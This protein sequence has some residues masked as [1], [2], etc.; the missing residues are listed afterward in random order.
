M[1]G[2][3]VLAAGGVILAG[4]AA[5]PALGQQS[6]IP[7]TETPGAETPGTETPGTEAPATEALILDPVV[8]T[9]RRTEELLED[10]PGSVV[11]LS[12]EQIDRS[13][14]DTT[15]DVISRLPNVS[16]TENS[17]PVDLDI[18]I[19]GVSNQ[20]GTSASGPTNG[21]FLNGVLLN[22]SG[23][24][25]GINATT[26]DLERVETILGPQGTAFGR[27]TIGGAI[28]FVTKKPT[29]TVEGSLD[30]E[31]GSFP[32]G[33]ATAIFNAPLLE[34]GL[35]SARLVAFGG[36]TDG[37]VEFAPGSE[38]DTVGGENVGVRFSLR[39]RPT[40]RLT[41]DGSVSFDRTEFDGPN[42]ATITSVAAGNPISGASFEG[43]NALERSLITGEIT[44]DF[45]IG[46]LISRSSF[47][48][49][50]V[51]TLDDSDFTALD[52]TVGTGLL[53]EQAISQELRF[54]SRDIDLPRRFGSVAVNV[55]TSVSFNDF[56]LTSVIDP[57]PDAFAIIGE[58]ILGFPLPDDG[59]TVTTIADQ[60]VFNFGI[61]GDVRWRPIPR[62]EIA[63]GARF[64]LDRVSETGETIAT[65]LSA[66]A[67][68][69]VPFASGEESFTAVTPNASIKYDW[70]DDFSTYLS[71]STGFR[72]GGFTTSVGGFSSFD[73]ERARSVEG[74]FRARF[75][76]GRLAV[77]G[78]GYFLDY[79]DIQVSTVEVVGPAA[80]F[81][82]DNAAS[83]RSV[84]SEIAIAAAPIDGLR[85]DAVMGLNFS[86]FTDFA[87][88]PF[89][90]LTGTRLPNAPVH[91]FSITA[92][93]QHPEEL[94]PGLD[95]F[96]RV[97]YNFRSSFA[98]LLDPD[99]VTFD[100]F[101]VLTFRAGLRGERVEVEAFVENA[102]DEVFATGSTSLVAAGLVGAPVNV[103]VGAT[104]RFGLR[105]KLLF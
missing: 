79:D 95:G 24:T 36:A 25:T 15:A 84:G 76:D 14:I 73:E 54:Q 40:E 34:D 75:F 13:N 48:Q 66:V 33:Q 43:E 19:R 31:V 58:D 45:D 39:S 102:L 63:A 86:T 17:S 52:F 69:P 82:I 50:D 32:D 97:E 92:D 101:D 98:N 80:V 41:L 65:G 67:F 94:L 18:S 10:V 8:V 93:Y 42:S 78:S 3:T 77:S 26:V 1:R 16:F 49:T 9:A 60:E 59:S 6:E 11:V 89:G 61:F 44:Y 62:L 20:I 5:S 87:D 85:I 103:D 96:A 90:D 71:F 35:L 12:D 2:R 46:T 83:A 47:F 56:S 88:S 68:P 72:A 7:E 37:F 64:N 105:A 70:T 99:L 23:A 91:T 38:V 57:G 81:T 29:D 55:G 100:G 22:P 4:A 30:L 74:G 28:N 104:R 27:G 51:E 53:D 21:I